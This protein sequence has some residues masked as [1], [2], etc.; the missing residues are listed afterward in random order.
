MSALRADVSS[1]VAVRDASVL[2]RHKAPCIDDTPSERRSQLPCSERRWKLARL[3]EKVLVNRS[4][5]GTSAT[6]GHAL[7][8]TTML[9]EPR[10]VV[11]RIV[12]L[13]EAI[14]LSWPMSW[15]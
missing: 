6:P 14:P 4:G 7:C 11:T 8:L 2:K 5:W 12:C 10:L 13:T 9:V 1:C 15:L 3:A